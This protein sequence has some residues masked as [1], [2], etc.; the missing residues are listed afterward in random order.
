MRGVTRRALAPPIGGAAAIEPAALAAFDQLPVAVVAVGP[1]GSVLWWN[2]AAHRHLGDE[3]NTTD[4]ALLQARAAADPANVQLRLAPAVDALGEPF[5]WVVITDG[6]SADEL[7]EFAHRAL[8]D[9]LTGLPNRTLLDDRLCQALARTERAES[10][11]VVVFLDLDHFKLINDTQ[12]HA[13]GDDLLKALAER[14]QDAVRPCDTVARFGGDE[15]VVVCEGVDDPAEATHMADRLRRAIETPLCLRGE[16]VFVSASLGVAMGR[17][18]ST[19]ETLL[20][21]ADAAMYQAKL[22]GRARTEMFDE[23]IRERNELRRETEVAL[24]RA[25]ERSEFELVYQPIVSLEEGWIVGAEALVRWQHPERGLIMPADFIALAEETG[26]I[27]PIGAWVLDEACRQL[28]EW[29]AAIPHVPLSMAVNVSARQLRG[30]MLDCV[31]HTTE[32]HGVD[33]SSLVLEITEGMLM[34][35]VT[36]CVAALDELRGTGVRLAIDDFGVG[37]SSLSYLKRFPIDILKV[38]RTFIDGLGTDPHDSAIVSAIVGMARALKVSLVAEG[39]ETQQQLYAL[40][41]LGCQLAQGYLFAKP[42]TP[43]AFLAV[44]GEG[45][46]W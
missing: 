21:D 20:R 5:T 24:R 38:D 44:L 23:A 22:N 15:F 26:H 39:V 8:H 31:R 27:V 45:P 28:K 3:I 1:G 29:R 42:L 40:R 33:P 34:E 6:Y 30:G 12:G 10:A 11:V 18:G 36:R 25:V 32:R 13:A 43:E 35:D 7:S 37:Y 41:H 14:L 4:L 2:D 17:S 19:P 46:R 9:S 16:E